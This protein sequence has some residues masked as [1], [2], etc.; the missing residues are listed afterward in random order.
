MTMRQTDGRT[1]PVPADTP[2]QTAPR[3]AR[4]VRLEAETPEQGPARSNREIEP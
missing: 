2:P 4:W 1:K 3:P